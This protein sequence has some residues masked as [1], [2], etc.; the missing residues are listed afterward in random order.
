MAIKVGLTL[1]SL[2]TRLDLVDDVNLALAANHLA[3][4]V[5]NLGGFDGG[6]NFHKGPEEDGR[7]KQCQRKRSGAAKSLQVIPSLQL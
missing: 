3:G 1:A 5:T 7:A 4:L 2:V 6:N